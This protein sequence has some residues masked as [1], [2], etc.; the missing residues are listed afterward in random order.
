MK[1]TWTFNTLV[2]SIALGLGATPTPA[3]AQADPILGQIMF[4]GGNFCPRNWASAEGQL[5][6]ISQN[7]AL[8][9]LFGT[10]YGGD[11]RTTF[12]LP[13]LRGR[14]IIGTGEGKGL[15][16]VRSGDFRGWSPVKDGSAGDGEQVSPSLGIKTCVALQG[17]YP[18]RN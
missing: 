1:I 8:F 12:G 15:S 9:S 2:A 14:A 3:K 13:D 17:I 4:F 11:G 16:P 10:M 5:L 6:P 7:T 18:S